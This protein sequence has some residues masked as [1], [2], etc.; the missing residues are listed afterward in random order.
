VEISEVDPFDDGQVAAWHAVYERSQSHDRA[1][2]S[3][4]RLP[5][6]EAAL[7]DPG[8]RRRLVAFSG[9]VDGAVVCTGAIRMPQLD[10]LAS[11]A[12]A[13]DTEPALR[14]RG[15]GA[16]MLA[17]LEQVAV[18]AGR[19]LLDTETFYPGDA[20]ADGAGHDNADF[21]THRGYVFGLGDV[22]RRLEL[23]VAPALLDRLAGEAAPHHAAYQVRTWR[24]RVPDELVESFATIYASLMTEAPAGEVEREPE[25]ADVAVLREEEALREQQG[26]VP[27]VAVAVD[28]DGTV[29]AFTTVMT[30][31]HEPG[32]G[33]Q[34]GTVV[35]R[36][37]RGHRLG[38]AVK[39][40][41][42][43]ALQQHDP[44]VRELFTY[45]AEVNTHMVAINEALGF[46]AVERLGE[47]QKRI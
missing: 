11:A 13:V 2:P 42:L 31:V 6:A 25:V 34:W 23:P 8:R 24:G 40:A 20:P 32:R 44:P 18:A 10:N 27:Y 16:A 7:R 37:H 46:V 47:F 26:R 38:I 21:L 36:A 28:R 15:Y 39:V 22:H 41:N 9:T 3:P 29:V 33:Y 45:N 5:E 35:D 1:F 4:W 19:R 30:T 14:R 12:L 17:H 43:R